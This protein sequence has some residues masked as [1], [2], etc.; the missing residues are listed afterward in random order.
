[1]FD[2]IFPITHQLMGFQKDSLI[3][4]SHEGSFTIGKEYILNNL[5]F[6]YQDIIQFDCNICSDGKNEF[7]GVKQNNLWGYLRIDMEPKYHI[8]PKYLS[9]NSLAEGFALVEY[10]I[11]KFGYI[12]SKGTEYFIR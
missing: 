7:I 6:V 9:I 11:G 8:E 1:M 3:A 10:E 12:D 4:F 2:S 5:N